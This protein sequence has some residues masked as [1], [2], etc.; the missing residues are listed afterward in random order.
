MTTMQANGLERAL[1][2]RYYTD[3]ALFARE[4]ERIFHRTW[5]FA[6][7]ASQIEGPGDYF[8]FEVS[9][10]NLFTIR[11]A[12]GSVRTFFNVCMHR[13]HELVQGSGSTKLIVCPY[14]AWTYELDGRLRRAPNQAKVDGFDG[15]K[16]CLTE[17][18]TEVFCGFIFV[19]LDPDAAP[20]AEWFPNVKAELRDY[21]PDIDRL[22]T[23]KIN[24]VEEQCNWKVAVE[25]YNEC[26][27]CALCHPTF[28]KGVVD[29]KTYNVT[30]RDHCL[31]HTTVA[32]NLDRLTYPVDPH[33]N[34]H[35]TDYSSWFLWPMFSFQ[36]YPGNVLNTYW[37]R[38][39]GVGRTTMYRGWHAE[40]GARIDTVLDL[41]QQDLDTT[42]AE[43]IKLVESV[44]RGLGSRGYKPGPLIID[45][46]QGVNSEHSIQ[47]LKHW[48]LEA[49]E[50]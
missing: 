33:A 41:A 28:T 17:A 27:H 25:N 14:H 23:V 45:R 39:H 21:V 37:W 35:A 40:D 20:M 31:R 4:R 43:D 19:N 9:G 47:A 48:T 22:K 5:Q 15:S 42:V 10:Q 49:L 44:Q 38:P 18:R 11:S 36:V 32:A 12:D 8:T 29:A 13:A 50:G 24:E 6:G 46:D 26:Y 7:H 30:P 34:A 2:A 3:Q 1:D 16:I